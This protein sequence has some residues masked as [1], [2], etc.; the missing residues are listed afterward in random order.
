MSE[1]SAIV[2]WDDIVQAFANGNGTH[3][4]R[5]EFFRPQVDRVGLVKR[6]LQ[7]PGVERTA[8]IGCLKRMSVD[9]QKQAFPELIQAARSAHGP[10]GA[11]RALIQSLPRAWVLEHIDMEVD[12]I[13]QGEEYDDYWMFLELYEQ[14]DPARAVRLARRAANHPN[15]DIRELALAKVYSPRDNVAQA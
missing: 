12:A 15:P 14:L 8:A 4:P 3:E 2:L 6:A 9:E 1:T 11:V 7:S 13:L 10:V 5:P